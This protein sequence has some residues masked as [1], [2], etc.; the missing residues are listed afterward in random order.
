LLLEV[1]PILLS[2]PP[3]GGVTWLNRLP[4]CY[5]VVI[6]AVLTRPYNAAPP[7]G[8]CLLKTSPKWAA[9]GR[10]RASEATRLHPYRRRHH[11]GAVRRRHGLFTGLRCGAREGIPAHGPRGDCY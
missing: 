8:R 3:G 10:R 7:D 9:R 11:R 2:S 5:G 6:S 4:L 1:G